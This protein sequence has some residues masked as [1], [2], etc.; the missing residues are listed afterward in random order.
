M[1]TEKQKASSRRWNAGNSSAIERHRAAKA[2]AP[3]ESW[4]ITL[5][6]PDS[7]REAFADALA[8]RQA[9]RLA[10]GSDFARGPQRPI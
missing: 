8:R 1:P 2:Q 10:R 5:A 6:Q 4:W 7:P 9:E 3:K